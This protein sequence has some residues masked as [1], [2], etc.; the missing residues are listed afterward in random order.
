[1]RLDRFYVDNGL[2]QQRGREYRRNQQVDRNS[3]QQK[4]VR[5]AG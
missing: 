2:R 3:I 4:R 5:H 1:M